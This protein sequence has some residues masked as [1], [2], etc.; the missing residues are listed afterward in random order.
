[1]AERELFVICNNCGSEVSPYVTECPYC[2]HRLRKRAPD[3]KKVKKQEEKDEK[4]AQKKRD[5]FR[6]VYEGGGEPRPGSYLSN[7]SQLPVATI[8]LVVTSVVISLVARVDSW[9]ALNLVF[10]GDLPGHLWQLLSAPLVQGGFGYG[11]V[12]LTGATM[13]GAGIEARYGPIVLVLSWAVCGAFGVLAEYL[14]APVPFTNGALAV[15]VGLMTAWLIVVVTREDLRDYD[16]IGLGAVGAVL[17]A[18]P[19]VTNEASVWTLVGGLIGGALVGSVLM[20][21][22]ARA[23]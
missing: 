16:G 15:A 1:M 8:V 10:L 4:R 20:R 18:L 3:L 13:F 21:V 9:V 12:C 19:I 6:A 2:G 11:F 7:M 23:V 14:I 5:K 17:L 22:R